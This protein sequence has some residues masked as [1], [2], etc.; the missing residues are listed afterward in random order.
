M[1]VKIFR[2]GSKS[3][4][5]TTAHSVKNYLL[6]KR[7]EQGTAHIIRGDEPTT[8]QAID[9]S[10]HASTYFAGCLSFGETEKALTDE[11]K[12]ALMQ[13]FEDALLPDF[14]PTRYA[15]YWVEHT[16]KNR[17]EL[18]F[19]FAKIDLA[20]SKHLDVYTDR[21]DQKRLN[22]WKEMQIQAYGLNDPND[23]KHEQEL[24][25]ST[26]A[27]TRTDGTIISDSMGDIKHR[28]HDYLKKHIEAG[29]IKDRQ[30]VIN[31]INTATNAQHA[32]LFEV[33]RQTRT[34]ITVRHLTASAGKDTMRLKGSFY[35]QDFAMTSHTIAQDRQ[36][37]HQH[38]TA[39]AQARLSKATADYQ[40]QR[41]MRSDELQQRFKHLSAT[42]VPPITKGQQYEQHRAKYN[43]FS[44]CT[45]TIRRADAQTAERKR[46]SQTAVRTS[47]E[48][49]ASSRNWLQANYPSPTSPNPS[50]TARKQ[51][52]ETTKRSV[53]AEHAQP[54]SANPSITEYIRR[55][56]ELLAEVKASL[57]KQE[58]TQQQQAEQA[59][60]E[61]EQQAQIQA[62]LEARRQAS[63]QA[64]AQ[65][66]SQQQQRLN[67]YKD[68]LQSALHRHGRACDRKNDPEEWATTKGKTHKL[69]R[70]EDAYVRLDAEIVNLEQYLATGQQDHA[71]TAKFV[72][73][74]TSSADAVLFKH[75]IRYKSSVTTSY[76]PSPQNQD[77]LSAQ[78]D[79]W[80]VLSAEASRRGYDYNTALAR[81]PKQLEGRNPHAQ[82]EHECKLKAIALVNHHKSRFGTPDE[83]YHAY[84]ETEKALRDELLQ[85]QQ[86]VNTQT[87]SHQRLKP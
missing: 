3:S 1:L 2:H 16:D 54:T 52:A 61:A 20:T 41:K 77:I 12:Q 45:E 56:G 76:P 27:K 30:D 33:I 29:D 62:E 24:K 34:S 26:H 36:A 43:V 64:Q 83:R 79:Y 46:A 58:Q 71:Q 19:V 21:R 28:L 65:Q 14:D 25:P 67:A 63:E 35:A 51:H 11:Q 4:G 69:D 59:R 80:L 47:N 42:L 84:I 31:L 85:R 5:N 10:P 7:V 8:S 74:T 86:R 72:D 40:T 15:C 17:L 38:Y 9:N 32:R 70:I 50:I 22:N 39:D 60:L 55:A 37:R 48:Y 87:P 44:E 73:W 82:T 18:N 6:N 75:L 66:E 49:L 81:Y 53:V 57:A 68:R 13:S 78:L 23:P